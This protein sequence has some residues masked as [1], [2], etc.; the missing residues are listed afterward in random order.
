M[1]IKKIRSSFIDTGSTSTQVAVGDH[2]HSGYAA[3]THTH[4]DYAATSHTHS[5][6]AASS[7]TH[8]GLG[9]GSVK[10]G[11]GGGTN[12]SNM[13]GV[14]SVAV[15]TENYN[16][17]GYIVGTILFTSTITKGVIT[18]AVSDSGGTWHRG[19]GYIGT[20]DRHNF[21]GYVL[22]AFTVTGQ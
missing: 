6:Y 21:Q 1:A 8:T 3:S 4:S 16:S 17:A 7:H 19:T 2:V 10:A 9:A 12:I 15:G 22:Q 11:G 13:Y 18:Q 5:D 20:V 14:S